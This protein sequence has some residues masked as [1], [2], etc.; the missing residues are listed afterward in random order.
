MKLRRT[1]ITG[2][3][4]AVALALSS[5]NR[6]TIYSHYEPVDIDG[7]ERNDTLSFCASTASDSIFSEQ[8]GLLISSSY[9]FKDLSL[10]IK[11]QLLH[12][13]LAIKNDTLNLMLANE[14]GT[15]QGKGLNTFHYDIDLG[16]IVLPKADTLQIVISHNMRRESLPGI[17]SIGITLQKP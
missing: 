6:N 17:A 1:N 3:I 10:I 7:W 9:P 16:T 13:D 4:I 12:P 14:D 8:L 11:Q 2:L 15:F 5:C